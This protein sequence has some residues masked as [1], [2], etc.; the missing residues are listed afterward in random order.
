M[1]KVNPFKK[2][3]QVLRIAS[4]CNYRTA[5]TATTTTMSSTHTLPPPGADEQAA[6][7]KVLEL[8]GKRGLLEIFLGVAQQVLES[9]KPPTDLSTA[10]SLMEVW[11]LL[12]TQIT[13]AVKAQEDGN[14]G[15]TKDEAKG[16]L[17]VFAEPLVRLC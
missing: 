9:T 8:L 13:R 10:S 14:C 12:S 17:S 3:S 4:P 7:A 16:V 6:A 1:F 11:G 15:E 5:Q 2:D